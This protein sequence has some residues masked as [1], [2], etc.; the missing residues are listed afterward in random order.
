MNKSL[1]L[2]PN[3]TKDAVDTWVTAVKA[4]MADKEFLEKAAP[5]LGPYPQ[6]IG[7]AV[8]PIMKESFDIPPA[9]RKWLANYVKTRYDVTIAQ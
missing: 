3:T 1:L 9:A 6:I 2:H 8:R 4:M 7:E 5:E